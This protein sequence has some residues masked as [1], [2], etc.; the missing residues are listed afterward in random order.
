ML[1]E[2]LPAFPGGALDF[3]LCAEDIA[4]CCG[5]VPCTFGNIIEHIGKVPD[6]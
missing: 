2:A 4:S 1:N 6:D 5:E 3:D